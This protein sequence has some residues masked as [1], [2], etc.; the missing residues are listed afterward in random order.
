[1]NMKNEQVACSDGRT[2][3][4]HNNKLKT[5]ETVLDMILATGVIPTVEEIAEQSGVSR[6]SVFRFFKNMDELFIEVQE[7]MRNRIFSQCPPPQPDLARSLEET[8]TLFLDWR[9]QLHEMVMPLRKIG[10]SKKH[11]SQF[12]QSNRENN[13]QL[14]KAFV[15][16]LFSPY[17]SERAD[18]Q[19]LLTLI[20]LNTSW[21]TWSILRNDYHL[22]IAESRKL[23]VR[24][25][26]AVFDGQS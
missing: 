26:L 7:M 16:R 17:L 11:A 9:V 23:L 3:R 15:T 5:T 24:Q 21:N 1:M 25:L 12:V 6:R 22:S 14:E 4:Q 2:Q 19:A 10:E 20:Q 18:K 8:L 13:L